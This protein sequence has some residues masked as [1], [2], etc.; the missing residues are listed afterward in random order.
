MD[1]F[2]GQS[3]TTFLYGPEAEKLHLEFEVNA[4]KQSITLS[5]DLVAADTVSASINGVA[6]TDT[7]YATSHAAT[8][9]AIAAKIAAAAGVATAT[10]AGRVITITPVF[11]P[12]PQGLYRGQLPVSNPALYIGASVAHAGLGTAVATTPALTY[13]IRKGQ[14]VQLSGSAELIQRVAAAAD[15]YKAIGVCIHEGPFS[16]LVTVAMKGYVVVIGKAAAN[17]MVPGPVE[18]TS[19]AAN[20]TPQYTNTTTA[21]NVVGHSLDS[22][23]AIGDDVRICLL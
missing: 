10:A 22:S 17:N 14:L 23:S 3:K 4:Q 2:G 18:V 20:G 13:P 19:F 12:D 21:A 8:M 15:A 6:I 7:L 11:K 1:T 16:S 5:A 9:T